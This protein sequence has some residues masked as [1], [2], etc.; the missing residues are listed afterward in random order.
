MIN[1]DNVKEVMITGSDKTYD[2]IVWGAP[3]DE[4]EQKRRKR[5]GEKQVSK[6]VDAELGNINTASIIPGKYTKKE[7]KKMA[8]HL[9]HVRVLNGSHTCPSPQI[10]LIDK[11]WEQKDEFKEEMKKSLS[12]HLPIPCY[13]PGTQQKYNT[14]KEAYPSGQ[15]CPYS[16][17]APVPA[18][19]YL[20]PLFVSN[21]EQDANLFLNLETFCPVMGVYEM[22][23]EGE[24][25][26]V[27][28]FC[29]QATEF[30]NERTWGNLATTIF[31]SSHTMS[32]HL[33]TIEE[34]VAKLHVG[35]IGVNIWGGTCVFFPQFRWGG[36]PG[37]TPEDIQSGSGRGV[38]NFLVYD[39]VKKSVLWSPLNHD[40]VTVSPTSPAQARKEG[41]RLAE[42]NTTQ[43]YF[44]LVKVVSAMYFGI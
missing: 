5:E 17:K 24:A 37:N 16:G 14:F 28:T 26:R 44:S 19:G 1:D 6:Q 27:E 40:L 35:S 41:M 7:I 8:D 38:G 11:E 4:E 30:V 2:A 3:R 10:L 43:S 13:Y 23:V 32:S 34:M 15:T 9:A 12:S 22:E 36:Y 18:Q 39:G 25:E 20:E 33:P 29:K 21:I 31:S 42:F